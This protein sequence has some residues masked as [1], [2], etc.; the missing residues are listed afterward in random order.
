MNV[1]P[2]FSQSLRAWSTLA[3]SLWEFAANAGPAV[4]ASISPA[5][6]MAAS[7]LRTFV[8]FRQTR[9]RALARRTGERRSPLQEQSLADPDLSRLPGEK[10]P[11]CAFVGA[12]IV[13][14]VTE[15]GG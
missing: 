9:V 5:T 13:P 1:P 2:D 7:S 15:R 8:S 10:L 4:P 12:P 6:P 3:L 11:L 14:H